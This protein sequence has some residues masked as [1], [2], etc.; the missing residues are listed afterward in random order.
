MGLRQAKDYPTP[1]IAFLW[2]KRYNTATMTTLYI[3]SDHAGYQMKKHLLHYLDVQLHL[4]AEDLGP[5][6][7]V[8]TDDFPDYAIPLA[9][10]VAANPDSRGILI[11]GS[12]HGVCIAANKVAGISAIVG[13]SIAA[14]ETGRAHNNANVLCLAGRVLSEDHAAAIVKKFLTTEFSNG[15]RFVRR[16]DKIR[17][18]EQNNT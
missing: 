9:Q 14:A 1:H 16:N 4:S 18:V 12:G 13:Y 5:T 10:K 3:A 2:Q 8:E 6:A 11:C 7:Y 17:A 15:E